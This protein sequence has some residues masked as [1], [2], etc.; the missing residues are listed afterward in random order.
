MVFSVAMRTLIATSLL[1]GCLAPAQ[2]PQS[3]KQQVD[4]IFSGFTNDTPGCAV[5][6][7]E[8]GNVV[9]TAGYGM[10]DLE[11]NVIITPRS[12]FES[13]SVA[14]QFTAAALMLLAQQGKISLDDPMRKYLPEL[15]DYGAP[16]TIRHVIHHISGLREWRPL[17]QFAGFPEG[18][19]VYTNPD[20]LAFA[21]RQ[22]ALNFDP[23]T[24]YTYSNTGY[25]IATILVERVLGGKTFQ[26]FTDEAIFGPLAMTHTRWRDDF[27]AVVPHRALAYS[28]SGGAWAQHTPI[29]NI[30][31][32]GGLLTTVTDLLRWNENFTHAKV[33][34]PEFVRAQ[35]TPAVL[36]NGRTIAYAA[37]LMV[38][39]VDGLREVAHSGATGGYRT[40]LGRY[41]DKGVSV[42][43]LCNFAQAAPAVL[44]RRTARLWT[45]A[46]PRESKP[47]YSADP[48]QLR[49]LTGLYRRVRDNIAARIEWKDGGLQLS[50]KS[51][52]TALSPIAPHEFALGAT[53]ANLV[54]ENST[55]VRCRTTGD[56]SQLYERVDPATP[57]TAALAVFAGAYHSQE[58][59]GT[60]TIAIRGEA[61]TLKVGGS[62]EILLEPTF[63]DAFQTPT[64]SAIRFFR[65]TNG[66]VASF[67]AGDERV[68]D[69]RFSRVR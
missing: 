51:G 14:K 35:Q 12:V 9:L 55:P 43:V 47:A 4:A 61:L 58:T 2:T 18:T 27:R 52:D 42:A 49:S 41:P 19:R 16:L 1:L 10:A 24:H 3:R 39:T 28:R 57:S 36:A 65:D 59:G 69:L 66:Q 5:G 67:S 11:R 31:G 8:R 29:E 64:G 17:A 37:G 26:A 56:D 40:W 68:W 34:G 33:G 13:G 30:I 15:P 50:R 48:A 23:G 46:E 38:A 32:A 21:A 54:C 45:G 60:A 62:G 7:S 22:A 63:Q 53:G 44:G 6:V 20:L 25:N